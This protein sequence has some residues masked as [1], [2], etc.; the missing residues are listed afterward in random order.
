MTIQIR[1]VSTVTPGVVA[2]LGGQLVLLALLWAALRIG[3]SALA[4]GTACAVVTCATLGYALH[5]SQAR[6][7]G[8]ANWVTLFR[9]TLVVGVAAL[10]ADGLVHGP[11]T[12]AVVV[13]S[14][15]ALVLDGVDGYVARRTGSASAVGARFDMEVDAFLILVL[16]VFVAE[17]LGPWVLLIGAMRYV[18]V[19][20]GWVMPWL[21]GALP[22]SFARKTVAAAQGILLVVAASGLL[23]KDVSIA[24]VALALGSLVWSFGR[25]VRWLWHTQPTRAESP[26][27]VA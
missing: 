16:S 21:K 10:V 6:R 14:A 11:S 15:V 5:R 23:P 1:H 20:A 3:P 17:W 7:F 27:P 8:Q 12:V 2:G 9:A 13:L 22:P 24:V 18:F 4:A 25:D 19:A 26:L